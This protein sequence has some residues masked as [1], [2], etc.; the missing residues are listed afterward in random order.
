MVGAPCDSSV[1]ILE[2]LCSASCVDGRFNAKQCC[3]GMCW[4]V[5][6]NNGENISSVEAMPEME[7]HIDCSLQQPILTEGSKW[8]IILINFSLKINF[9]M[10]VAGC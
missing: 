10:E 6:E 4:C 8:F 5:D 1:G 7:F 3:A 2:D 9:R